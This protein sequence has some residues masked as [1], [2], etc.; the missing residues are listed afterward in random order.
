MPRRVDLARIRRLAQ[1]SL[2]S[3]MDRYEAAVTA[4]LDYLLVR[5]IAQMT[6]VELHVVWE[7]FAEDRLIVALNNDSSF[8]LETN[9]VFGIA[10]VPNGLA[11]FAARG[12]ER[13]FDFRSCSELIERADAALYEA[14]RSGRNRVA[15]AARGGAA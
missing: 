10:R 7:R 13:Y 14:K 11:R 15:A 2:Q 6:A 4:K 5:W 1:S 8:F 12:G 3:T 9:H